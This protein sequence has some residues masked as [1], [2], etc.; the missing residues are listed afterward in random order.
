MHTHCID[1]SSYKYIYTFLL[2]FQETCSREFQSYADHSSL[3]TASNSK[4]QPIQKQTS[5]TKGIPAWTQG[6][7]AASILI[8]HQLGDSPMAVP[9]SPDWP[10][11]ESGQAH[12]MMCGCQ[13]NQCQTHPVYNSITGAGE[14]SPIFVVAESS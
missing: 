11:S 8:D 1:R 4:T 6:S 12:V 13:N 10:Q 2:Q 14:L 9:S 3:Y 5:D 7:C